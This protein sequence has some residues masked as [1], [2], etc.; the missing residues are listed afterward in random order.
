MCKVFPGNPGGWARLH[1]GCNGSNALVKAD[2]YGWRLLDEAN[3]KA[4]IAAGAVCVGMGSDMVRKEVAGGPRFREDHGQRRRALA[5]DPEAR[6][7]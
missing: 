1:Q 6:S 5:V 4:W 2:A 7:K 3:I